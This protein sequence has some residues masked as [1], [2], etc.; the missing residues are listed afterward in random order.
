[1]RKQA[2]RRAVW[3]TIAA[4]MGGVVFAANAAGQAPE[5]VK[6]QTVSMGIVAEMHRTQ[7]AEHF[8]D[9]VRYLAGKL[10]ATTALE[11]KVVIAP[12]P[13]E[14]ARLIEQKKVDFYMESA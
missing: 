5:R 9:F 8:G 13:F 14:L 2:R 3:P 4:L 1:M 6:V 10:S 12:T 7:I 11:G